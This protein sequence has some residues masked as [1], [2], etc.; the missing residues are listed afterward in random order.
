MLKKILFSVVGVLLSLLSLIL[1]ISFIVKV[2]TPP[3]LFDPNPMPTLGY[4]LWVL[5]ILGSAVPAFYLIR[6]AVRGPAGKADDED[7][8]EYDED[9]A[10]PEDDEDQGDYD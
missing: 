2:T 9:N 1:L 10:E 4:I 3:L 6:A 8:E 7:E 5:S